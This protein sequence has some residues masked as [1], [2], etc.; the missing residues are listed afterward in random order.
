MVGYGEI[1]RD[2]AQL[3]TYGYSWIQWDTAGYS[4]SA[5]NL[6]DTGIQ[7]DTKDTVRYRMVT[8]KIQANTHGEGSGISRY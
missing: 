8:N 3:D 5:T 2:T 4:G 6:L 7:R 1:Q